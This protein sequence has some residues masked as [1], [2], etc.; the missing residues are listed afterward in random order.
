MLQVRRLRFAAGFCLLLLAGELMYAQT[1]A[2]ATPHLPGSRPGAPAA[3]QTGAIMDALQSLVLR[4]PVIF[5]GEVLA[6]ENVQD[7]EQG[8]A[9]LP[10]T[11]TT[12]KM[13]FRVG[14]PLR[15]VEPGGVFSYLQVGGADGPRLAPGEQVLVF[16]HKPNAGGFS[17]LVGRAGLLRVGG[18][19]LVDVR[20]LLLLERQLGGAGATVERSSEADAAGVSER[21]A[22]AQVRLRIQPN[23]AALRQGQVAESVP[24]EQLVQAIEGLLSSASSVDAS[25]QVHAP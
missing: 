24:K 3:V 21:A 25:E 1:P 11:V 6:V 18:S 5:T 9:F 20:P 13:T 23:G 19:G 14:D 22:E 10:S 16:L 17:S 8:S 4:S 12:R 2:A 7:P 15:G